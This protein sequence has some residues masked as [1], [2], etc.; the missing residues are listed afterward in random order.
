MVDN[1]VSVYLLLLALLVC[2]HGRHYKCDC[3]VR[4]NEETEQA[5]WL[6]TATSDVECE[7]SI[8]TNNII[9]L[10]K[11]MNNFS[12][13]YLS[14]LSL[15]ELVLTESEETEWIESVQNFISPGI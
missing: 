12:G 14:L 13:Q 4:L 2:C 9:I 7:F 3:Y 1:S 15:T 11:I 5:E 6:C 8:W 10:C